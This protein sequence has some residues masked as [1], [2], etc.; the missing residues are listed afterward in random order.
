MPLVVEPVKDE[1]RFRRQ[2]H[3]LTENTLGRQGQSRNQN[4]KA[5]TNETSSPFRFCR[6]P[7][8]RAPRIAPAVCQQA[9]TGRAD[10]RL[11]HENGRCLGAARRTRREP[12]RDAAWGGIREN[13]VPGVKI[14]S[15]PRP[16]KGNFAPLK[17]VRI[18]RRYE[19]RTRLSENGG[20]RRTLFVPGKP[21]VRRRNAFAGPA[22]RG[23][24]VN[25]RPSP[26]LARTT[27]L[28]PSIRKRSFSERLRSVRSAP[29]TCRWSTARQAQG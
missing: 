22:C 14:R 21:L 9:R 16:G 17:A 26:G 6:L 7:S 11:R 4:K 2:L 19:W 23:A 20:R 25:G 1:E 5:V 24:A 10:R 29:R 12:G 18:S 27:G 3:H 28:R 8:V 13:G 15:F